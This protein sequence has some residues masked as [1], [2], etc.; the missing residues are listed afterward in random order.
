MKN[1]TKKPNNKTYKKKNSKN[2][3][4][5]RTINNSLF[6]RW[7]ARLRIHKPVKEA[8]RNNLFKNDN[9]M[10]FATIKDG[11]II[12]KSKNR[13]IHHFALYKENGRIRAVRLTHLYEPD[14]V[15]KL[16]N[17][18]LKELKIPTFKYPSGYLDSYKDKTINNKNINPM[19]SKHITSIKDNVFTE[20]QKREIRKF[21]K[22][23]DNYK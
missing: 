8:T 11:Y 5:Q 19:D 14:K 18:R 4:K 6:R 2:T 13:N 3:G 16:E 7:L 9:D 23:K 12:P 21:V 10:Y 17:N 15:K 1:N 22:Y 20:K